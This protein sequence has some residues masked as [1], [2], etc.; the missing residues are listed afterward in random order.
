MKQVLFSLALMLLSIL[1]IFGQK[2]MTKTGAITFNSSTTVEKIE[3]INRGTVCVIDAATGKMEFSVL[4]KGFHFEK[5][6]MEEH[7]NEDY[8]ESSKYPKST[9]KGSI[10]DP[11]KVNWGIDGTYNVVVTGNLTMK[12]KTNAVSAPGTII[13]K[14]GK[15]VVSSTFKVKP[16]DYKVEIP[17]AVKAN[18]SET[19]TIKV[20][21]EL[22]KMKS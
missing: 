3:A 18:I 12:D 7:F 16:A 19:V 11:S 17:K 4:M 5:P 8:V 21:C 22:A 20:N 9:F 10:Q 14:G 6:L 1:P 15:V 2:Y 13:I